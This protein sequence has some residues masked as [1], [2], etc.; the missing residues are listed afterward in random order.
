M[1]C[2]F[3]YFGWFP[4]ILRNNLQY[5]KKQNYHYSFIVEM[6]LKISPIYYNVTANDLQMVWLVP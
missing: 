6:Q 2:I 3:M 5:L 1:W 4:D